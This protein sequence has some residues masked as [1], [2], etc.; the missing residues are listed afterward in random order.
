MARSS[1]AVRPNGFP[2]VISEPYEEFYARAASAQ[3]E[4]LMLQGF[5]FE[6]ATEAIGKP[7]ELNEL[8][9]HRL[10]YGVP[11]KSELNGF[12]T[13]ARSIDVTQQMPS[14]PLPMVLQQGAPAVRGYNGCVGTIALETNPL[15]GG[16]ATGSETI[17]IFD[18][19]YANGE[20]VRQRIVAE[21]KARGEYTSLDGMS[22]AFAVF[23]VD[24]DAPHPLAGSDPS[25]ANLGDYR[26][27]DV[28][29]SADAF[30]ENSYV[31]RE[32]PIFDANGEISD[33]NVE[34]DLLSNM[35]KGFEER[36]RKEMGGIFNGYEQVVD[37]VIEGFG[38]QFM[39]EGFN[40]A[41]HRYNKDP[42]V[43]KKIKELLQI[44]VTRSDSIMNWAAPARAWYA[45]MLMN[46]H[47]A[48]KGNN[49][50]GMNGYRDE[51]RAEVMQS[52]AAAKKAAEL[53]KDAL[54]LA[55]KF[56]RP[57]AS[58]VRWRMQGI[59]PL[60]RYIAKRLG[61]IGEPFAEAGAEAAK[62][63]RE[64]LGDAQLA[65]EIKG[66]NTLLRH[67]GMH[68]SKA[69]QIQRMF[70]YD[71]NELGASYPAVLRT[72]P[73]PEMI[74]LGLYD[75]KADLAMDGVVGVFD[76]KGPNIQKSTRYLI[77]NLLRASGKILDSLNDLGTFRDGRS[78]MPDNP[79]L[80]ELMTRRYP[81]PNLDLVAFDA[82]KK[83]RFL[84]AVHEGQAATINMSD[85]SNTVSI[86][87][88][89]IEQYAKAMKSHPDKSR[90]RSVHRSDRRGLSN[91]YEL[92]YTPPTEGETSVAAVGMLGRAV[93]GWA[94]PV[95]KGRAK[96][97]VMPSESIQL[98]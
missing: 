45:Y 55:A 84:R 40:M 92:G 61:E 18:D 14:F 67:A 71:E 56:K 5:S 96:F 70:T 82:L 42:M 39:E 62:F 54:A 36:L 11:I 64:V 58:P 88:I 60:D 16:G 3:G 57:F 1:V 17:G 31:H 26:L 12:T 87:M 13:L 49:D 4:R 28:V 27:L 2:E 81:A 85:D 83:A 8:A 34:A 75:R 78:K 41:D 69:Q 94:E 9:D 15:L 65:I 37:G 23:Q 59:D 25:C 7:I 30:P 68:S 33:W 66:N 43:N 72:G 93:R 73:F 86:N 53:D 76:S 10:E 50:K 20:I 90:R 79:T 98:N 63:Y 44:I 19:A 77:V 24:K 48:Q 52:I 35:S 97:T 29:T 32:R 47:L 91:V 51:Q 46:K 95:S 22:Y 38:R 6:E 89:P 74:N 80:S 21:H